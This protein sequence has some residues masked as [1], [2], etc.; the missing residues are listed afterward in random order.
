MTVRVGWAPER[1][2]RNIVSGSDP[3]ESVVISLISGV[4]GLRAGVNRRKV[5][6]P[7]RAVDDGGISTRP[8][9]ATACSKRV[10]G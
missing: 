4:I 6:E 10:S 2:E 8:S 5:F 3:A 9:L 7:R 1:A